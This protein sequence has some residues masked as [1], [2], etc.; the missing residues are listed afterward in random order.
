MEAS[1]RTRGEPLGKDPVLIRSAF[2]QVLG[3]TDIDEACRRIE[4]KRAAV[5]HPRGKP[6]MA[7]AARARELLGG[8][9]ECLTY[10]MPLERRLDIQTQYLHALDLRCGAGTLER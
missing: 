10:S 5:A 3:S 7:I 4:S 1:G 9:E 8:L 6:H 2:D